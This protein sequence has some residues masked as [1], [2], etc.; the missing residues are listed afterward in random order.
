MEDLTK[1]RLTKLQQISAMC[2]QGMITATYTNPA[3]MA[4]MLNTA[5]EANASECGEVMA[6]LSVDYAEALLDEIEN[7]NK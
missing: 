7:Q 4:A 2:L 1:D 5:K 3:S 6:K